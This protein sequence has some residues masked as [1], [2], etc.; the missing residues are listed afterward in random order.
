MRTLRMGRFQD[1]AN[2]LPSANTELSAFTR[3][4]LM[5]GAVDMARRTAGL[6]SICTP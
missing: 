4:G 6:S 3:M 2:T 5:T 1:L